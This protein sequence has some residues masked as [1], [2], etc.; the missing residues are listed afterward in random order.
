MRNVWV[1]LS[2][3]IAAVI[4][5]PLCRAVEPVNPNLIPEARKVLAYLE[6]VYGKQVLGAINRPDQAEE[7]FATTGKYPVIV[8]IDLCGWNSPTWGESYT[9]NV[10]K[11]VDAAK[12]W[13]Q[14]GGI[15]TM[16]W[17]W[18]HPLKPD[19]SAWVTP[20]KGTGPFD[21]AKATTPGTEEHKAVMADL[22]KHG[23]YL[24]QI[25]DARVPVLWRPLHEIDG[26]WFW[27]TDAEAPENTAALWRMIFDYFVKERHLDNLIWVYNSGLRAGN[28]GKDVVA[29]EY[30]KR[31]YPGA[32]YVDISGIDI[33]PSDW[34]GWPKPQDSSYAKAFEIMQQVSPGKMLAFSEGEAIPNP[35]MMA[36]EGPKWLYC[37]PWW[38]VED[39]HPAE[40]V[41]KTYGHDL[42]LTLDEVPAEYK[43]R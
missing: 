22:A 9:K 21:L 23:D 33:Y 13:W 15:V 17:H 7:I 41:K 35:D 43:Q 40:W 29:I 38:G 18:K 37:L 19:G 42:I 20:P 28:Q 10:Q 5:Q 30:R 11:S 31:F 1:L 6:S 32:E 14:R 2:L 39:R 16:Q 26:G 3:Y 25:L 8:G 34:Y 24:E 27:W 4:F 12:D 36:G